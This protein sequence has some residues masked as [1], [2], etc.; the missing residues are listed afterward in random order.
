MPARTFQRWLVVPALIGLA[1]AGYFVWRAPRAAAPHGGASPPPRRPEQSAR[2]RSPAGCSSSPTRC[3]PTRRSADRYVDAML[4]H[5]VFHLPPRGLHPQIARQLMLDDDKLLLSSGRRLWTRELAASAGPGRRVLLPALELLPATPLRRAASSSTASRSSSTTTSTASSAIRATRWCTTSCRHVV[6]RGAQVHHLRRPRR[7]HLRRQLDRQA[8]A[9]ASTIEVVAPYLTVPER[10]PAPP[11]Y[12]LLGSGTFQGMPLFVYLDAPGF[13][14]PRRGADPSA[15]RTLAVPADGAPLQAQVAVQLRQRSA[16]TGPS[17]PLPDDARAQQPRA[18]TAGSPTTSPT[19]T[20]PTRPSRRCGTTAG[21]SCASTCS[22]GGHARP[23]GLSLLR[24]QARLRQRHRLRRAGAAQGADLPARSELRAAA[25]HRTATATVAPNGARRRS[26]R[27]PVLGRDLLALDRA[28]RWPSS[29]AYIRFRPPRCARLLPAMAGDVR[30]WL[31]AYDPDGDGLPERAAPRVTGYD[32]DIL[33]YWYFNGTQLDLR[34]R[35]AESRARRLRQLRLRQR[36]RRGASWRAIAGN[37]A[38]AD[39]VRRGIADRIRGAALAQPVGRRHRSSS[40]RSAPSDHARVPIRELHGFFPFTTLLAP[41]EPR[42]TAAL[43]EV[44]RSRASSGRAIP[45]VITS[46]ATTALDLGDGR[47]D[48]ATSRRTRSAW[49]RARC[50]RRSSTTIR[51]A[52]RPAHFMELMRRYND[53][54]YPGRATRTIRLAAERARVLLEVGAVLAVAAA[55]S[56]R[57]SRT[58]STRCTAPWSSKGVVGLTPR[59][60]DKI[61]LQP[62]ALRVDLLPARSAALPRPRPDHRLGPAG[63]RRC[64]TPAIPRASRCTSTARSPSRARTSAT[65][66]TTRRRTR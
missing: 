59:D 63:R 43:A 52:S 24:R 66:S 22:R 58:T 40:T 53:L 30:A 45:P 48:A 47:P 2:I 13:D 34:R 8:A 5:Q 39:R 38:L 31:T 19:S 61:E 62:M 16:R 51:T 64:A 7:R 29:T 26:A 28:R 27:Q 41:D 36:P 33:S 42:Y 60:D 4:G 46:L 18:T 56:R 37:A 50:C 6:D 54:V 1:V 49:G 25:G 14:A 23:Q 65:S 12:P 3:A 10:R 11:A 20:P 9:P 55:R 17:T 32:L 35:P 21:G 44:R 15:P 57:T